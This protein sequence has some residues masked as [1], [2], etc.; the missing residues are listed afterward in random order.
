MD[1]YVEAPGQT[2][3]LKM[4]KIVVDPIGPDLTLPP[5]SLVAPT[6]PP[7]SQLYTAVVEQYQVH[8]DD[9]EGGH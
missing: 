2:S 6:R 8:E 5:H 3:L 7:R 1:G 9:S 4:S